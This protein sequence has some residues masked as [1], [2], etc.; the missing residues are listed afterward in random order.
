MEY[1][2]DQ[3]PTWGSSH[4]WRSWTRSLWCEGEEEGQGWNLL[5]TEWEWGNGSGVWC[6][7]SRFPPS[8]FTR[9]PHYRCLQSPLWLQ[10]QRR[11]SRN[12]GASL[13]MQICKAHDQPGAL[14]PWTAAPSMTARYWLC[15][16]PLCGGQLLPSD[17]PGED[18]WSEPEKTPVLPGA[19][20]EVKGKLLSRVQ[21][22]ATPWAIQSMEF[23]KPEY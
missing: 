18:L 20:S 4:S 13:Q 3:W 21:L 11:T 22:F 15:T 9:P 1:Q 7:G 10:P 5:G 16:Q 23:S 6:P 2:V 19:W 8:P 12:E 14:E 17:L